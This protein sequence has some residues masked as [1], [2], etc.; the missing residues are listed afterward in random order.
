[1]PL[2]E[3]GKATCLTGVTG[4]SCS[5]KCN[6]GFKLRGSEKRTCQNNGQWDGTA[7]SCQSQCISLFHT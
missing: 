1:M 2:F 7:A 3:D 4:E 5:F 6:L